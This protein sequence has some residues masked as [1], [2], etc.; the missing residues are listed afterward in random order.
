M[1]TSRLETTSLT[2]IHHVARAGDKAGLS[3]AKIGGKRSNFL[4]GS[5]PP[6][7]NFRG[8]H[9]RDSFDALAFVSSTAK[10]EFRSLETVN[11]W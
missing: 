6:S 11:V 4:R 10:R 1:E 5:E 8:E 3:R 7:G 9:F 2:A